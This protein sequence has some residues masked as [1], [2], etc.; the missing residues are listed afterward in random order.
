[1][2]D[3]R[4]GVRE[5]RK[6]AIQEFLSKY[7]KE[8]GCQKCGYNACTAALEFDHIDRAKK[9]FKISKA[10]NY[11]WKKL[12]EELENCV[13]LCANCHR[14]KTIKEKDFRGVEFEEPEDFQLSLL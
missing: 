10:Y 9:N 2:Y 14:E 5:S 1:M 6:R 13:L 7:K 11:S 8:N 3:P 4:K 12:F